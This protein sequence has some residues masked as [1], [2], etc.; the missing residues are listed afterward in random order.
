MESNS[1][2]LEMWTSKPFISRECPLFSFLA[3]TMIL[4]T[5]TEPY[6]PTSRCA[7]YLR[8]AKGI[9]LS[10]LV[11]NNPKQD[12]HG[13]KCKTHSHVSNIDTNDFC[14]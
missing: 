3:P 1:F 13:L 4:I 9:G 7:C 5:L 14:T 11:R 2:V 8:V 6:T 12:F 10:P